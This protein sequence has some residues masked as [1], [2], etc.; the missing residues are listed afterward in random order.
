VSASEGSSSIANTAGVPWEDLI[1]M[2]AADRDVIGAAWDRR[3]EAIAKVIAAF[4]AGDYE[5]VNIDEAD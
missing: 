1:I 4:E 3:Q 5:E 2:G